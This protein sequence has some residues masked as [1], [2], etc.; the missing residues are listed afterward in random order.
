MSYLR[1]PGH[2][3]F[4]M[5]TNYFN[6]Q[7]Y[8]FKIKLN[9]KTKA[10][11]RFSQWVS[12]VPIST[13]KESLRIRQVTRTSDKGMRTEHNV[14]PLGSYIPLQNTTSRIFTRK[15]AKLEAVP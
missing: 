3:S 7:F 11:L 2:I 13:T 5:T 4:V 6:R 12:S 14:M 1:L 9:S 8:G 15:K 10:P